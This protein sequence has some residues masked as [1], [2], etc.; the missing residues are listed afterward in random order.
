MTVYL[1]RHGVTA[2]NAQRRY[3]GRRSDVPL[4]PEG[5]A[6]LERADF[7]VD[8][9]FVSPMARARETAAILFPGAALVNVPGLEEM[10]FGAFEGR[11]AAEMASDPAYASWVAGNCLGQTPGGEDRAEFAARTRAA[12]AAL[13]DAALAESRETLAVVAHGGVQMCVLEQYALPRRDYWRWQSAPGGG[14]ALDAGDWQKNRTLRLLGEV[15]FT[16]KQ[17]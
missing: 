5:C 13:M 12:F 1:L 7:T 17:P 9:V 8:T 3:Q 4:S 6:A 15:N 11:T 2:Y 10:D 14:W 16:R